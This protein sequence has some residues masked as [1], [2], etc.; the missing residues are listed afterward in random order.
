ML[1]NMSELFRRSALVAVTIAAALLACAPPTQARVTKIII[2]TKV[3]P[4]F[5]GQVFGDVGQYETIAGRVFGEI[6]PRDHRHRI[7]NDINLAPKNSRGNVEYMATFFL[8]K[9]IDMSKASGLLWQDVPNRGGRITISVDLRQ[10]G[11]VGLSSGWQGD[12]SGETAHEPAPGNTNDYAVVPIATKRDGSPITGPVMG[13]ILNASGPNSSPI[14][15]HSNPLAYKPITLDT[16]K[17][18]LESHDHETIDGIVTGVKVIPSSDWAWASCDASNPFP[19]TPDPTQICLKNGFAPDKVHQVVFTA[20]DPYVLAVGAAAFRD[21][22]SFF[23]YETQDD[24]GTPNPVA[25]RISWVITR[26]SSQS[27]T[28]VRQLIHMGMTQDEANRKVYDGAW[29]II[30][31]RRIAL[32]FRFAKPDLVLKL[33][34]PGNEGPLWWQKHRDKARGLP[35]RGMLDRCLET[36]SCPKIIEHAGAAEVWGQKLTVGWLGTDAKDYIPLPKNV[37]RYYFASTPHGGGAGGFNVNPGNIPQ[38]SSENYGPGT[39]PS[40]PLPQTQSVN[41]L[42]FH[43]RNWV[44]KDIPPPDSVYPRIHDMVKPSKKAMGFPDIPA[45]LASANPDAPNNFIQ[46]M[47]DYDWGPGLDYSDN[48]G[49]HLFEPPIIK[50][51]LP[52]RVP[53]VDEDG[54]ELGG[55]PVVLLQAPLGTYLGWNITASGFHKGKVCNYQGGWIPFAKTRAERLANGDPRLSLQER[56]GDHAGYVFA[57]KAAAANA[58]ARGFLLQEDA[59]SLIAQAEASN[60][61]NP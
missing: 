26:G 52:I 47:L 40:N 1:P 36:N 3:S 57:V 51:V 30:A 35:P 46:A 45:V 43:F 48:K 33:Y 19:G 60:V 58:M 34:E 7:I 9:P 4:A 5:A 11:D 42:R 55:V 15:E 17:A 14:I 37:R 27:G 12:N 13:R 61:L 49:F 20:K 39:F 41:A 23:R 28:F 31:G 25:D 32:N 6:D 22:A 50:Q 53:R 59:D 38:C 16:S 54:N 29:P 8:V 21:A 18:H 24:Y 10:K 44:M 56:Y 2:D